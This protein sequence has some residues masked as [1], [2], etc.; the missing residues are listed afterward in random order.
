MMNSTQSKIAPDKGVEVKC[1]YCHKRFRCGW[2]DEEA[3]EELKK[4]FPY[5]AKQDCDLVCDD[6]YKLYCASLTRSI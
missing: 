5:A 6:C 1:A 3:E 2:S 4:N